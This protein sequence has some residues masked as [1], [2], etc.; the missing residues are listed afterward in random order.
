MKAT[1]WWC[2]KYQKKLEFFFGRKPSSFEFTWVPGQRLKATYWWPWLGQTKSQQ[3]PSIILRPAILI[4]FVWKKGLLLQFRQII[5]LRYA[6][7]LSCSIDAAYVVKSQIPLSWEEATLSH[8]RLPH[9]NFFGKHAEVDLKRDS[10]T[11]VSMENFDRSLLIKTGLES[12]ALT[13][14]AAVP[15]RIRLKNT[16]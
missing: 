7:S 10:N 16:V 6:Q 1:R 11:N 13:V 8:D 5:W 15:D 9:D 2:N 14:G 12:K 3:T 4:L